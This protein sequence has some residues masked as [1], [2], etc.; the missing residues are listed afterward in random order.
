MI[1][2]SNKFVIMNNKGEFTIINEKAGNWE[3]GC[4]FSNN[5][6]KTARVRYTTTFG[7]WERYYNNHYSKNSCY[8]YDIDDNDYEVEYDELPFDKEGLTSQDYD[9][10]VSQI[11][12][13]NYNRALELGYD[14]CYDAETKKLVTIDEAEAIMDLR[15]D[16]IY[17]LYEISSELYELYV[18]F[19][20]ELFEEVEVA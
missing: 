12:S 3:N 5:G 8:A 11:Q 2:S 16:Y 7:N 13:L 19:I 4:W 18:D 10:I 15:D 9:E 17:T 20:E 1:G 6:H 14:V